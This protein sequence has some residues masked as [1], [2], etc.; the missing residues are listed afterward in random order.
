MKK[1]VSLRIS[2][3]LYKQLYSDSREE[4]V[5]LSVFIERRLMQIDE[6]LKI[7]SLHHQIDSLSSQIEKLRTKSLPPAV[8]EFLKE[9]SIRLDSRI[10]SIVM[11]RLTQRGESH[12]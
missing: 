1:T 12:D 3:A 2:L 5:S 10:P 9:I 7:Q 4:G 11:N 6:Q 8:L